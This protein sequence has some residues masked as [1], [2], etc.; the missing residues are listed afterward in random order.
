ML[1]N[2]KTIIITALG[3]AFIVSTIYLSFSSPSSKKKQA[4]G[5]LFSVLS[6]NTTER[7]GLRD[8]QEGATIPNWKA[9]V[10]AQAQ[11]DDPSIDP[12]TPQQID[13]TNLN[14]PN[15]I[16]TQY[17]K[18]VYT[19]TAVLEQQGALTAEQRAEIAKAIFEQEALKAAAK[20]YTL[21]AVKTVPSTKTNIQ[22]YGNTLGGVAT[23]A[24][25]EGS[26]Y[27]DVD[28]FE[29]YALNKKKEALVLIDKKIAVIK[30][31][32]DNLLAISVPTSATIYHLS[33]LNAVE[34]YLQTLINMRALD[35]DAVR[36]SIGAH[37]YVTVYQT[38]FSMINA[39]SEYFD[40]ENIVFQPT[41]KGYIFTKG[42][43]TP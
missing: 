12:L 40:R 6:S 9:A 8:V 23:F 29:D 26:K 39:F 1:E 31:L 33:T 17:A 5:E 38:V 3:I 42:L 13:T 2:K 25:I 36:A 27:P 24:I 30:E 43:I 15:N 10:I 37:D 22:K 35:T 20:T 19:A 7:T 18:N 41:D 4:S 21:S 28:L 32:R 34:A 16:T 14:D 11:K